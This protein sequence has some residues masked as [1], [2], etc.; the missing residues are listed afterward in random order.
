MREKDDWLAKLAHEVNRKVE[1][2][3]TLLRRARNDEAFQRFLRRLIA[4]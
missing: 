3:T 4:A 1:L 2:Q